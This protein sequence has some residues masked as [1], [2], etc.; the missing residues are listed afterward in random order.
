MNLTITGH[1]VDITPALRNYIAAKLERINHHFDRIVGVTVIL[2]V[3]KLVHRA[4]AQIHISGND[5]F[6]EATDTDMYAAIDCMADKLD[7]AIIRHKEKL[8]ENQ[9]RASSIK[10]HQQAGE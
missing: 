10:K 5:L 1:H 4:E 6:A 8:G 9:F 7:R 2:S 3:E